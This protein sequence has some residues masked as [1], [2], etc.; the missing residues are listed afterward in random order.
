FPLGD[1]LLMFFDHAIQIIINACTSNDPHVA[2]IILHLPVYI[3]GGFVIPMKHL[4]FNK[5][6]ETLFHL[7]QPFL[8]TGT[9]AFSIL[10]I[11]IYHVEKSIWITP[12][13]LFE[14]GGIIPVN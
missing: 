6:P 3:I 9:C 12:E 4:L 7:G 8:R 10:K 11:G 1:G 2:A 5:S 14:L 13:L